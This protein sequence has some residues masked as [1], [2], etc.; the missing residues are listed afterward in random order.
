MWIAFLSLPLGIWFSPPWLVVCGLVGAMCAAVFVVSGPDGGELTKRVSARKKRIE[1][2]RV[3]A[4]QN[5]PIG[6]V[7]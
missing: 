2:E 5:R 1:A 7:R 4:T 6:H 3:A